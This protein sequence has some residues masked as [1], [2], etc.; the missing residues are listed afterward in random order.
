MENKPKILFVDDELF[1]AQPYVEELERFSSVAIRTNAL[2]AVEEFQLRANDYA[3]A[4]LDVMLPPPEGWEVKT[5]E[6]LDTGLE[7]LRR[8]RD[9]IINAK[10]PVVVLTHR[11]LG[12]VK[13]EV[14]LIG[15]PTGQIEVHNKQETPP[16]LLVTLIKRMMRKWKGIG[17]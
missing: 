12:Y 7:V 8:C 13:G 14:A 15:F 11:A 10:L 2:E 3:C 17:L 4:V 5:S 1:F 16:F 6:G 9:E